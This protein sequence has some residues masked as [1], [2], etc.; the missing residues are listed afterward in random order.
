MIKFIYGNILD[1]KKGIIIH[2]VNC[3]TMGS[4][5]AKAIYKKHPEVKRAHKMLV[6]SKSPNRNN[7]LL[8][9]YQTVFIDNE[10]SVIN[11]FTQYQFGNDGKRYTNYIAFT[12]TFSTLVSLAIS[13]SVDIA[14][15]H[16]IGCGKGGGDWNRIYNI[17][18]TLSLD[19]P[20]DIYI[21]RLKEPKMK[22]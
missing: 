10:L 17:I 22:I 15:P 7:N 13:N 14:I 4:G 21:Y 3:F 8:G 18:E 16:L 20:Y 19:F 6:K 1:F 2:Q 9:S 11:M 5:V 12:N